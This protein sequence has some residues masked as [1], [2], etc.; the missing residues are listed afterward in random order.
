MREAGES[1]EEESASDSH[2]LMEEA[3]G[4]SFCCEDYEND[5]SSQQ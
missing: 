1:S 2:V 3:M 4:W 5:E